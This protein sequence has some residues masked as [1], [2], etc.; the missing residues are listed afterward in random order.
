MNGDVVG[1][2]LPA[3]TAAAGC[4]P[5]E[6]EGAEEAPAPA[7][8]PVEAGAIAAPPPPPGLGVSQEAHL[9]SPGPFLTRQARHFHSPGFL[10]LDMSKPP[11]EGADAVDALLTAPAAAPLLVPPESV[12]GAAGVATPEPPSAASLLG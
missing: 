6:N 12:D 11:V 10:N 9:E 2:A 4:T 5:N 8:I 7:R 1:A 3:A